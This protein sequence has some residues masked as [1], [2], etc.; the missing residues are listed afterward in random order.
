[1]AAWSASFKQR[2]TTVFSAFE[3]IA[4]RATASTGFQIAIK[5]GRSYLLCIAQHRAGWRSLMKLF[6]TATNMVLA[7]ATQALAL[8]VILTF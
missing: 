3:T 2:Q 8:G 4:F 1:L 7:I 5:R 6:E